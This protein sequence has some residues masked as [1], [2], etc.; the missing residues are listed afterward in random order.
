MSALA[1]VWWDFLAVCHCFGLWFWL[2][3]S[4]DGWFFGRAPA[5]VSR[6]INTKTKRKWQKG[7]MDILSLLFS[8][9]FFL[10][11]HNACQ[12]RLAPSGSRGTCN[13]KY[14]YILKRFNPCHKAEN[15]QRTQQ[16]KR[17]CFFNF[18]CR[19]FQSRTSSS[20]SYSFASSWS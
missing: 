3:Q 7:K 1:D 8:F 2:P 13:L 6:S 14:V 9:F 19:C 17:S 20:S 15:I 10:F 16:M 5:A 4:V 11:S 12:I 18:S